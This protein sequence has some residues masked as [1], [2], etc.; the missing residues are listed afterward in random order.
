MWAATLSPS[1]ECVVE[2]A[3][4]VSPKDACES[5]VVVVVVDTGTLECTTG[6]DGVRSA[7]GTSATLT[8]PT[9]TTPAADSAAASEATERRERTG[10]V[11]GVEALARCASA[12][13]NASSGR[14]RGASTRSLERAGSFTPG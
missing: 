9:V 2:A 5:L 14:K 6:G 7:T 1:D 13:T 8:A 11:V 10:L 4:A 3:P 12:A